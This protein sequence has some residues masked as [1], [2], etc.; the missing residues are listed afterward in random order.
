MNKELLIFWLLWFISLV[1]LNLVQGVADQL[2]N[3][4]VA[5]IISGTAI[6]LYSVFVAHNAKFIKWWNND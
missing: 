2:D 4:M 5:S 6:Y 3:K 1:T